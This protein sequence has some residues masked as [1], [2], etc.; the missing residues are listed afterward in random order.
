MSKSMQDY[1]SKVQANSRKNFILNILDGTFFSFGMGFISRST[2]LPLFVSQ[3]TD[4]KFIISLIMSIYMLGTTIPQ[5]FTAN[6]AESLK[7]NIKAIAITGFLQRVPFLILAVMTFFIGGEQKVILLVIFFILWSAFSF[8]MGAVI[9]FW[10][11]MVSKVT[12]DDMRGKLFGYKGFLGNV[13]KVA[14]AFLAGIIIKQYLFPLNFTILFFLT[15]VSI[16]LSYAFV[17][18]VKEPS[19][20]TSNNKLSIKDYFNKLVTIIK[21]KRNFK[22]YLISV[23]FTNF[24]GMVNG[25]YSVAA[26]E[27][28][29]LSGDAAGT[30]VSTFTVLLISFQSLSSIIWGH[31]S[32]KWGHKFVLISASI[33]NILGAVIAVMANV[34]LMFYLVFI[35]TGTA[36]GGTMVSFLAI[37][38]DFCKQEEV[39]SY[40]AIANIIKGLVVTV[41]ALIGGLIVDLFNYQIAFAAAAA[42]MIIGLYILKFKVVEPRVDQVN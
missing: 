11:G 22:M 29:G 12:P 40:T 2:I 37:I 3:L 7:K 27:R 42:M 13:L 9:P 4:S 17:V 15:F 39:P 34:P 41:I 30:M 21:K 33:L 23:V 18:M 36:L 8:F 20:P 1:Q 25:L 35:F 28:L 26:V 10:F 38:P 24:I 6:I 31:F 5:L 16:M 19:Y 32:D 14:G